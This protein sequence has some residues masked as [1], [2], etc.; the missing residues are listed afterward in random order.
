MRSRLVA[1]VLTA[2]TLATGPLSAQ[3][4]GTNTGPNCFPFGCPSGTRYQQVYAASN[5]ASAFY[6]NSFSFFNSTDQDDYLVSG[7]FKFY[8]STTSKAVDALSTDF[9]SNRGLD[10][11]LFATYTLTGGLVPGGL[12]FFGTPFLYNP[13]SGNLLI[14][15]VITDISNPHASVNL[16]AMA[17]DAGGLFS[18]MHDFGSGFAGYGLVTE[19]NGTP[20]NVV[21]EPSTVFLL[22]TGLILLGVP[23]WRRRRKG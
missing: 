17:R 22:G 3:L 16:D 6:I 11:T 9:D 12:T 5:F 15:M 13:A 21:P 20:T 19:F 2:T 18:R 8:L 23:A 14:D 1:V 7:M 10:N 4:I